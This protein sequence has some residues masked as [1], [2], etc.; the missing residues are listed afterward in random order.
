MDSSSLNLAINEYVSDHLSPQPKQRTDIKQK[1]AEL[2]DFLDQNCFQSGSYARFTAINPVHDL[3]VIY[4]V[5]PTV[6][7]DP[8]SFMRQLKIDIEQSGIS[9]I[10]EVTAQTHSLTI[11]FTDSA[12][13]FGIDVVPAIDTNEL[14][15]FDKPIY[16]VPEIL[17]ANHH[18]RQQR[19]IRAGTH[20][21][22]WI[23]SDPRGY[24]KAAVELNKITKNFR[25]ATKLGKGWRHAC[26][27]IYKDA[28]RLKSF[29]F[30]LMFDDYF[31]QHPNATTLDAITDCM[32]AIGNALHTPQFRDRADASKFVDQY[33]T[34]LTDT[35]K[36]LI[37]ELQA[38]AC[39]IID[40]LGSAADVGEVNTILD[41]L[42]TVRKPSKA[43]A[44]AASMVAA[45]HQPWAC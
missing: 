34:D 12:T 26:K 21:V 33:I 15:Q 37:L 45:P 32:N 43:A 7:D 25:H 14:N 35:E 20:P 39:D 10:Q 27:M 13:E 38:D 18:N 17:E 44:P 41:S 16:I 36:Q 22:E 3:D 4:V 40:Q 5:D 6:Y 42:L 9:N 23:K 31:T 2:K 11:T 29:H 30:E 19:Y 24:I 8:A 1:Y 28:F